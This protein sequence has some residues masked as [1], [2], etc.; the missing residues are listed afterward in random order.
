MDPI[1]KVSSLLFN[2]LSRFVIAFLPR[3]KRLNFLDS[4]CCIAR[5]FWDRYCCIARCRAVASANLWIGSERVCD[6]LARG[7]LSLEAGLRSCQLPRH[8]PSPGLLLPLRT[9]V[10]SSFLET[11]GAP[12]MFSSLLGDTPSTLYSETFKSVSL[13]EGGSEEAMWGS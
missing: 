13:I 1:G 8:L 10:R 3:S 5:L 4:Y 6:L 11:L 7:G 12:P 9:A 2:M